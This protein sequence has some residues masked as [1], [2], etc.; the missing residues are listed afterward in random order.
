MGIELKGWYLLAKEAEP[1]LRFQVTAAACAQRDLIVVVPWVLGNVI[2][3]S[4]ILFEP[5]IESAKYAADYRNYHWQYICETDAAIQRYAVRLRH[6]AFRDH[7]DVHVVQKLASRAFAAANAWLL[8]SRGRPRFKG[9]RQMDTVEGKSNHAGIRWR[10]DH[11]EWFGLSLPAVIDPRDQVITHALGCRAKDVRL[12]RR[13][14]KGRDRFYVQLVCEGVPYRKAR[15]RIGK[16]EVGLDIGPSTIAAVGEDAA[17]LERFCE[18]VVRKNRLIRRI[19]RKLDRQRLANNPDNC[20]PDGRVNPGPKR[21]AA[22]NRQRQ[23]QDQLAERLRCEAAHRRTRHGQL[24]NRVLALGRVV[25]M[26]TVPYRAFQQQYGRSV[27]V[28]APGRLV[29][30][31]RRKAASA[32]GRVVE[33]PTRHTKLSQVCHG[34]GTVKK[35]SLSQRIHVCECGVEMQRDLYSAYLARCVGD[36]D[37]LHADTVRKCWSGAEPLLRAAWSKATEP[38]NGRRKP[39]SFGAAPRSRSGSPAEEGRAQAE[40]PDA[41]AHPQGCGESRG[42]AAV[43]PLRTPPGFSRGEVQ[44]STTYFWLAMMSPAG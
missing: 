11:V 28:R 43:V 14:M 10:G 44:S 41:V 2:S 20:L 22:S 15:H 36:D 37:L 42:E 29:S 16:G 1:S 19:Q 39:S 12:V 26:E 31:L 3:G 38:A 8:G 32:G 27:S 18:E 25:K 34:C 7:L 6:P 33:F 5:F 35:K 17:F 13:K 24:A 23:T 4:P 40:V 21:W 30:M 9:D